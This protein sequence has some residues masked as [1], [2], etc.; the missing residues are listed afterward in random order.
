VYVYRPQRGGASETERKGREGRKDRERKRRREA[1][2][3]EGDGEEQERQLHRR[4]KV[5]PLIEGHLEG[6]KKVQRKE[7]KNKNRDEI[8]STTK[9]RR[10]NQ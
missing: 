2:R 5:L 1:V 7:E 4:T 8:R 6:K 10:R 3:H 9:E